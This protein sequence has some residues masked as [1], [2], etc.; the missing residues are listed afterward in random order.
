M[1][2]SQRPAKRS[3]RTAANENND[4]APDDGPQCSGK[5]AAAAVEN[6][7]VDLDAQRKEIMKR[8]QQRLQELGLVNLMANIRQEASSEAAKKPAASSKAKRSSERAGKE[9]GDDD[10]RVVRRS[11]RTQGQEPELPPLLEPLFRRPD[12]TEERP[13]S[14]EVRQARPPRPPSAAAAD[15]DAHKYDAHNL[16]RLRTMSDDAM[17]KRIN[18]IT[19]TLKL[20]SL[21]QLLR[22]FGRDEL[23][24]EAQAAL[25]ERLAC[26]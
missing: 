24:D 14:E 26:V 18:K 21:V 3:R 2:A 15:G 7:S 25:D 8:N 6:G 19:N 17:L 13:Y 11:L 16:H 12:A 22:E 4:E 1:P 20:S 23:A 9:N 10:K 5:G